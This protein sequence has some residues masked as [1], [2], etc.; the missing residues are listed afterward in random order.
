M[1]AA[2]DVNRKGERPL[3]ED[4]DRKRSTQQAEWSFLIEVFSQRFLNIVNCDT[5]L[6]DLN[7]I[8]KV[9]EKMTTLFGWYYG[10]LLWFTIYNMKSPL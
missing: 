7:A 1:T 10:C 4:L 6:S 3:V 9:R 2:N 8:E 5:M